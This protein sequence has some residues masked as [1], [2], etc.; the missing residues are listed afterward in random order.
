[1]SRP[2]WTLKKLLIVGVGLIGGSLALAL[3]R[4]GCVQTCIGIEPTAALGLPAVECGVI[5]SAVGLEDQEALAQSMAGAD[6][7]VLAVPMGQNL[8]VLNAI[9]PY[10]EPQTIVT[11]VGSVKGSVITQARAILGT[12]IRQFI[13]A[14]PIA[15][16]ERSGIAAALADL[17][18][19]C[20][21]VVCPLPENDP[22]DCEYVRQM[23]RLAGAQL[24]DLSPEQHDAIFAS[25]SHLPH[26]L[27]FALV[28]H[29]LRSDD[30]V[31]RLAFAGSGFRDFT[32]IAASHPQLWRDICLANRT[33]LLKDLD[34]YKAVLDDIHRAL[35]VEEGA[36]LEKIFARASAS[37]TQ[38]QQ[39]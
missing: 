28:E 16:R 30:A 21:V 38:W 6:M 27:S 31:Q 1:M 39:K 19:H 10:L 8:T 29:L 17:Y 4:A 33:Q 12:K 18:D 23:W 32:R 35:L 37:R 34:G 13:P 2:A 3:R 25:V 26:I 15:G 7:L 24:H 20:R 5:D 14:H 22:A 36:A 11:D 9:V